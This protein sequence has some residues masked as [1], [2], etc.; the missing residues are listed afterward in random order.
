MFKRLDDTF[1]S[2]SSRGGAPTSLGRGILTARPRASRPYAGVLFSGK[3]G[4][5][6]SGQNASGN[7]LRP[8]ITVRRR[9]R[10]DLQ[11]SGEHRTEA[12]PGTPGRAM[13]AGSV[14]EERSACR[15][16]LFSR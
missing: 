15:P 2:A 16:L 8:R 5:A 4:R 12:R 3:E 11:L 10:G 14:M 1:A 6:R 9:A 7:L 13:S